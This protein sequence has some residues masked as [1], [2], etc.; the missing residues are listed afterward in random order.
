VDQLKL[1]KLDSSMEPR[2]QLFRDLG[3][4]GTYEGSASQNEW[5]HREVMQQLADNG[6]KVPETLLR[7]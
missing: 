7:G 2:G 1:L 4:E 3:G 6:R 5:L